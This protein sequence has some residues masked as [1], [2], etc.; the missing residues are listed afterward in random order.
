MSAPTAFEL[1]VLSIA[2]LVPVVTYSL[3]K[4]QWN[5]PLRNG[6][7]FFS[8]VE[9]PAGFYEGP[10]RSWLKGYHA[11]LAALY[12][13]W[14][15]ALGAIVVS[16][17]W[18]MTPWWAGG[19][20]LVFAPAMLGFQAWTRHKLGM[21]PPVRPVALALAAP[22][23]RLY[24]VAAGGADGCSG[25]LQLVVAA[26]ERWS[27]LRLAAPAAAYMGGAGLAPRQDSG[28]PFEL[29]AA[30]RAHRRTLSI[31]G[32]REAKLAPCMGRLRLA[33]RGHFDGHGAGARLVCFADGSCVAMAHP[34]CSLGGLGIPSVR[35][36]PRE[37]AIGVD[38]PRSAPGGKLE[39]A[40]PQRVADEP[41]LPDLV[42]DLVRRH[43]RFHLVSAV[44]ASILKVDPPTPN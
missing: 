19:F 20:A 43:F 37:P 9:V 40:V 14:V 4:Y 38:G 2:L 25:W 39:D 27:A 3:V 11:M 22:A 7:G 36:R 10:G 41:T 34:G 33:L 31:S 26:E 15:V 5:Q 21:D 44:Q 17:R 13:V 35:T 30:D 24:L 12:L 32:C 42:H 8:G 23:G 29:S 16:R 28:R 1:Y 6:P 18:D